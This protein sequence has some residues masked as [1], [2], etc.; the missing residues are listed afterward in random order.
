MR[1]FSPPV[2]QR[3]R[4]R[5]LAAFGAGLAILVAALAIAFL[6]AGRTQPVSLTTASASPSLPQD[7]GQTVMLPPPDLLRPLAPPDAVA[8]NAKREFADRPDS[9]AEA[10]RLQSD[11]AS[12]ERAL[13]CLTQAVYYEAAA[14]GIDGGRAVAQVV[15]NRM[16]HP[17]YPSSVCGVIYQG[18]ERPTGCQFTF[19]CDGSLARVPVRSLWDQARRIAS[20]ALS[21]KVYAPVGHTTHYHADYVLPYW[22]DSLDKSRQIGRHIF[23]RL[24]GGLGAK[25]IFRQRYAGQEPVPLLPS[26]T[27]VTL[28]AIAMADELLKEPPSAA[29][30]SGLTAPTGEL[31]A[32]AAPKDQPQLFADAASGTLIAD[33][34]VAPTRASKRSKDVESCPASTDDKQLR[35]MTATDVRA[36]APGTGC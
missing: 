7:M 3:R 19:T 30:T 34:G 24:K 18:S 27:A 4:S 33:G 16:R 17:A 12:K 6:W 22:A 26:A 36:R 14:E 31:A 1:T 2:R 29:A 25:G 21:G 28:D 13:E 23:Y 20:E 32:L 15:L 9:P 5:R 11:P 35:P 10:F 8:E